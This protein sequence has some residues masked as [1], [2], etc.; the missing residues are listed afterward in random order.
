MPR[1]ESSMTV[2]LELALQAYSSKAWESSRGAL[3]LL[4]QVVPMTVWLVFL[5]GRPAELKALS[6]GVDLRT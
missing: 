4:A 3:C 5:V 2:P 6:R 1:A